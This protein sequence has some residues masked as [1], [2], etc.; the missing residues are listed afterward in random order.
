M[1]EVICLLA[2]DSTGAELQETVLD[3]LAALCDAGKFHNLYPMAV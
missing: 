2:D 3:L 1:S